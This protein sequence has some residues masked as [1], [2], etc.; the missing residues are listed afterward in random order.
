VW[1]TWFLQNTTHTQGTCFIFSAEECNDD[2]KL[3]PFQPCLWNS[4]SSFIPA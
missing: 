4:F 2:D 1:V 3:L